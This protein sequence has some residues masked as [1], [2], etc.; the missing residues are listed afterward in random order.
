MGMKQLTVK[1]AVQQGIISIT[2]VL[3]KEGETMLCLTDL[4]DGVEFLR[5]EKVE[6][7]P[8][9]FKVFLSIEE[10]EY[11]EETMQAVHSVSM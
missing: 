2:E 3:Q 5:E 4:S 1:Q 11:P 7:K 9:F 10:K 6:G 8:A